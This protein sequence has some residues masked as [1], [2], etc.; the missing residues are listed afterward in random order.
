MKT[1]SLVTMLF[2]STI[3][4]SQ[5][6]QLKVNLSGFINNNGQVMVGLYQGQENFLE[7]LYFGKVATISNK[8]AIVVFDNLPAG[9][10]AISLFHDE[11]NN[12]KLDLGWFGI[13]KEDYACSNG[14][15]GYFGPPKYEDAKF[16]ISDNKTIKIKI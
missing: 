14:A 3:I 2:F 1:I 9:E 15:K 13:P 6:Y 8:E 4:F 12:G 7:K 11:N 10:Y 16:T 5:N